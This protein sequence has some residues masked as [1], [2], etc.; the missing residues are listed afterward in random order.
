M[1]RHIMKCAFGPV[2]KLAAFIC[3][4]PRIVRHVRGK[5]Y[6]HIYMHVM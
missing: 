6:A 5:V 3:K 1:A 2:H 4:L